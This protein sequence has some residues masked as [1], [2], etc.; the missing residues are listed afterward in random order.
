MM[1]LLFADMRLTLVEDV[2]SS[3]GTLVV[4]MKCLKFWG[5]SQ[6]VAVHM[7]TSTINAVREERRGAQV[8][9]LSYFHLV[10]VFVCVHVCSLKIEIQAFPDCKMPQRIEHG[11]IYLEH[12]TDLNL[13]SITQVQYGFQCPSDWLAADSSHCSFDD[14]SANTHTYTHIPKPCH[15]HTFSYLIRRCDQTILVIDFCPDKMAAICP[16]YTEAWDSTALWPV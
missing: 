7:Q 2:K 13:F 15:V 14:K 12:E 3:Q 4:I 10:R 11:C 8:C 16:L 9:E 5:D 6:W 1:F